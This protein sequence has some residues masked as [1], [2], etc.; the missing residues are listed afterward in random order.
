MAKVRNNSLSNHSCIR[1]LV[2]CVRTMKNINSVLHPADTPKLFQIAQDLKWIKGIW[3]L[4][5]SISNCIIGTSSLCAIQGLSVG[6]FDVLNLLPLSLYT[7]QILLLSFPKLSGFCAGFVL[8]VLGA[9][10][11]FPERVI[12]SLL[13]IYLC[14]AV[15]VSW[16][17]WARQLSVVENVTD[18]TQSI[19]FSFSPGLTWVQC[20]YSRS[21][22]IFVLPNQ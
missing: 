11:G 21:F 2:Y 13:W 3:E 15:L 5:S 17:C 20:Q 4:W 19:W 1:N 9:D 14:S 6:S 10:P 7:F 12:V 22:L 16:F 18:Q 8:H